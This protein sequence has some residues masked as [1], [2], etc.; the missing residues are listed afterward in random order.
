MGVPQE[1]EAGP[2]ESAP[3]GRDSPEQITAVEV[4]LIVEP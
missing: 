4:P 2:D 3:T 1:Q